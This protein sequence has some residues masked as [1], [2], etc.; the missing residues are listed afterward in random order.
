[1][2]GKV[3]SILRTDDETAL[4]FS[5]FFSKSY[6]IGM[7]PKKKA[8]NYHG[9]HAINGNRQSSRT[10]TRAAASYVFPPSRVAVVSSSDTSIHPSIHSTSRRKGGGRGE[11]GTT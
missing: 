3:K 7:Y 10:S 5:K 4:L 6:N 2:R 1:M 8:T 11:T 9:C